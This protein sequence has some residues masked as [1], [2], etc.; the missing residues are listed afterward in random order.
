ME[1]RFR[2]RDGRWLWLESLGLTYETKNGEARYLG[3]TRNVT[4]R[5]LEEQTRRRFEES[6]QRSQRLESLG[7]LA[8]GIAHDFNNLLTPILGEAS[9][10]LEDL[11]P[12]APARA[13]LDTALSS[14]SPMS[15]TSRDR[16][17]PSMSSSPIP[18]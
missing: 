6:L 10:C 18:A 15:R 14:K 11:P 13:R 12:D 7:V 8:G 5:K 3:I 9:L 17:T 4:E 16:F 2:H 1:F